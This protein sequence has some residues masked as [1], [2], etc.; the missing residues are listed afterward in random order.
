MKITINNIDDIKKTKAISQE[1]M[2]LKGYKMIDELFCDSS[3]FGQDDEPALSVSQTF[4]KLE[5]ILKTYPIIYTAITGQGQFQIYLGIFIKENKSKAER[6][7]ANVLKINTENGYIIRLYDTN[8]F[9]LKNNQI[10]LNSGGYQTK[11]TKEWINKY[12]EKHSNLFISQKNYQWFIKSY[13]ENTNIEFLD[14]MVIN[15]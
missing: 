14:N 6:I 13:L 1:T 9:E 7:S 10:R 3:G 5:E 15:L 8:I 12:L 2:E 11:L 4:K